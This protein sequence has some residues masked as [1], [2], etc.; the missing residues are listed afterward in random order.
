M[1]R[2]KSERHPQ[3]LVTHC[4]IRESHGPTY[5]GKALV[6]ERVEAWIRAENTI[7][8]WDSA[9]FVY[10]GAVAAFEW[11]F[12]CTVVAQKRRL[13]AASIMR[14]EASE[15]VEIREYR[16]TQPTFDW[17]SET[18]SAETKET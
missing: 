1:E 2:Q 7:E 5:R 8:R 4:V 10:D 18:G 13:L 17:L 12:E 11:Q 6:K 9:N 16:V 15:I 3:W 14:F